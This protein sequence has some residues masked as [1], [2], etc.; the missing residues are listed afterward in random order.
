MAKKIIKR[1]H[2]KV[3]LSGAP[4]TDFNKMRHYFHQ[5]LEN[6]EYSKIVKEYVR[7]AYSKADAKAIFALPEYHFTMYSHVAAACHWKK[8]GLEFPD[9]YPA[10]EG[11]FNTYFPE[12]LQK[13]RAVL[14]A[15]VEE[16]SETTAVVRKSPAQLMAEKVNNTIL[17]EI[18]ELEDSWI[19]GEKTDF[20]IYNR[21]N[22]LGLK[23]AAVNQVKKEVESR[24]LELTDAYDKKCDQAVEAFSHLT[25][26]ETKRR[27]KVWEQA[28]T[29]LDKFK[30]ANK[31]V[32]K[33]RKAKTV[34]VSKQVARLKYKKKD[35]TLK[36]ASVDPVTIIGSQRL[37]AVN[38]KYK[39]ITEY[40]AQGPKG[41]EISGTTLKGFDPETSRTKTMRSPDEFLKNISKTQK[42]FDK[43]YNSLTTKEKVPNGRIN[44]ETVLVRV[45]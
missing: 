3:G 33:P 39:T 38:A 24:L 21:F 20:D 9:N 37:L 2:I 31:A 8:L 44:D 14:A 1:Q 15:K 42:Q 27:I 40:F 29:D 45:D 6:K 36:I 32:R 23:A 25:R 10:E 4:L 43:L 26:R 28:L 16:E 35:D 41:F 30:V 12:L 11:I 5:E 13:G 19:L 34:D 7:T 22:A 17:S 18:D